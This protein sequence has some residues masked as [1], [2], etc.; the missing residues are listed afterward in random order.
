LT[1]H[2]LYGASPSTKK[3][4]KTLCDLDRMGTGLQ[5][6]LLAGQPV[7]THA[8]RQAHLQRMRTGPSSD[9]LE[10]QQ[11]MVTVFTSEL[12]LCNLERMGMGLLDERLAGQPVSTH[13]WR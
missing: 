2:Y 13:A 5:D 10:R 3:P 1:L 8:S 7:S 12:L 4:D 6:E 9:G 11:R